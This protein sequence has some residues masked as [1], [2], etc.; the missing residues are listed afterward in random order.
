VLLED[1]ISASIEDHD[2]IAVLSVRGDI[3]MGSAS[4]FKSAIGEALASGPPALVIDLLS[5]EFLGSI[6]VSVLVQAHERVGKNVRF[7][8]VADRPVISRLVQ[9]L[10]L[11]E[12]F[13]LHEEL[14]DALVAVTSPARARTPAAVTLPPKARR[15]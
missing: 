8:V 10:R 7:A 2:G 9:M 4:A 5:V 1:P 15:P 11:D 14:K 6:G 12:V 3:D 13:S